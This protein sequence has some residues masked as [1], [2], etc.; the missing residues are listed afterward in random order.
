MKPQLPTIRTTAGQAV[1]LGG[2]LAVL[3][4]TG[5]ASAGSLSADAADDA[6][7]LREISD[8]IAA[9]EAD[10]SLATPEELARLRAAI[11]SHADAEQAEALA[12][13]LEAFGSAVGA[14]PHP[15]AKVG[16]AALALMAWFV[17]SS[18]RRKPIRT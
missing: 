2:L 6:A 7:V 3:A 12:A 18:N 14:V 11:A 5:C 15:L 1:R 9:Y 8:Q 13:R 16:G 10:P 4:L 17:V